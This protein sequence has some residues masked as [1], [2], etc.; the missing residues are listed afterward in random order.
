ML[1]TVLVKD[2]GVNPETIH[3]IG[4]SLGA[5]IVGHIGRNIEL[6]GLKGKISRVTGENHTKQMIHSIFIKLF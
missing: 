2:M 6:F 4:H 1:G 5:H 3:C